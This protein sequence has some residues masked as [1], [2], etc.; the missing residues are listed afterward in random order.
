VNSI[1]RILVSDEATFDI[2]SGAAFYDSQQLG[3][4]RY[5]AACVAS[6]IDS[7]VLHAGVHPK[8][9]GLHRKLSRVFP[10]GIYYSL[11]GTV[12]TVVRVMDLRRDPKSI[13][14]AISG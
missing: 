10:F 4:G 3:V 1:S 6:D 7:L 14:K 2:Q 13:K 11:N 12:V 9:H 8:R 5:F